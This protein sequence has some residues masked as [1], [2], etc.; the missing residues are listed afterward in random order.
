[1]L[2]DPG[3]KIFQG[4]LG[5]RSL[6]SVPM[7]RKGQPVGA[8]N[9]ARTE[10]G[11]ALVTGVPPSNQPSTFT[12]NISIPMDDMLNVVPVDT[13]VGPVRIQ[14]RQIRAAA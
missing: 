4:P 1:V 8:I 9:V 12:V 13:P 3:A 7:M 11:T 10:V 2:N 14:L 6:L 5:H